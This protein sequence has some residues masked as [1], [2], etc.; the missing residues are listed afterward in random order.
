MLKQDQHAVLPTS[1]VNE[2]ARQDFLNQ[3]GKH[4]L[5]E[6][7]P[8]NIAAYQKRVLPKIKADKGRDPENRHEIR[9]EMVR[10]P[11]YQMT[12]SFQRTVQEMM[13]NSVDDTIQRQLPELIATAKSIRDGETLGSLHVDPDFVVPAY[14]AENDHHCMPG[15]YSGDLV[16]DDIT[17]GALYDKGAF[18]YTQGLFGPRMDGIG[19]ATALMIAATFPDLKPKKMLE[20]GCTAGGSTTGLKMG[21]PDSEIHAIDVGPAV[22]RYA[23][24]RAESLGV[25]IHF[26]Q[27]N[28]EAMTF[29]DNTF[30]LVN[31]PASLHEMSHS[32]VYN[33]FKEAC[34]VLKPGGV[35]L[36][37][38]LPP[39]EGDD[40]WTQ[41]VRDWDTYNNNEPFW[42]TVHEMDFAEVAAGAGFDPKSY[43]QGTGPGIAEANALTG[44][45]EVQNKKFMGSTRGG[46]KAWYA[47]MTKPAA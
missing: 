46:G 21:F 22:L 20:I 23:H 43:W 29:E 13:W 9:K 41:F 37:S 14:V 24:A 44:A 11:Y 39:Y 15:G 38:E 42:G 28:G 27:M 40:P 25:A 17:A 35:F 12:S 30:D 18:I 33:V 31:C 26:H 19:K 4:V 6:I 5:N 36:L 2:Q 8:G 34:R 1:S 45:V 47:H 7:T 10:D 16:K 3:L 32:A